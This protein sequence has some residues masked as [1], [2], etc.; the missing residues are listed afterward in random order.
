M[1]HFPVLLGKGRKALATHFRLQHRS[2]GAFVISD[3]LAFCMEDT[4]EVL[5]FFLLCARRFFPSAL[6][7]QV[8]WPLQEQRQLVTA[9]N[10]HE[11]LRLSGDSWFLPLFFA[12]ACMEW[13][14]LWPKHILASGAIRQGRG[15]RC[16]S[17][18]GALHKWRLAQTSNYLCF[19]PQS[20]VTRLQRRGMDVSNCIALPFNTLQCL[21]IWREYV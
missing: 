7:W 2:S 21:N 15:L 4:A 5:D 11:P 19:L 3:H 9:L 1:M 13:E 16:V 20:N 17:I 10:L 12:L 8:D 18:G 14:R 6:S